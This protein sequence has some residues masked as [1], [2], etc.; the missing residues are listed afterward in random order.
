MTCYRTIAY[1]QRLA[2]FGFPSSAFDNYQRMYVF[3][4]F[5]LREES[6][7]LLCRAR[8]PFPM[9]HEGFGEIASDQRAVVSSTYTGSYV[10]P[11]AVLGH[12]LKLHRVN[13][14]KILISV[15]NRI[16]K[17]TLRPA[18]TAGWELHPVTLDPPPHQGKSIHHTFV[19]QTRNSASGRSTESASRPQYTSTQTRSS[20][21]TST[22]PGT[23]LSDS[24]PSWIFG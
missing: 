4:S 15:P 1:A 3:H 5:C 24:E 14:R 21:G 12:T 16:S 8:N 19:D 6:S 2:G 10:F 13:A 9:I 20:A 18:K 23:S 7:K 22:S 17:R 11:L